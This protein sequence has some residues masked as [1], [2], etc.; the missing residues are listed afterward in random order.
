MKRHQKIGTGVL[1]ALLALLIGFGG[2]RWRSHLKREEVRRAFA[3]P[4][5]ELRFPPK[6]Y[7]DWLAECGANEP[8]P[9]TPEGQARLRDEARRLPAALEEFQRMVESIPA[10]YTNMAKEAERKILTRA[11]RLLD[12]FGRENCSKLLKLVERHELSG[13][14]VNPVFATQYEWQYVL[15]I[16]R[17]CRIYGQF[18]DWFW[19]RCGNEYQAA[20]ADRSVF[21]VLQNLV[22]RCD[23]RR[24]MNG[25]K[26]TEAWLDYY[27]RERCDSEK[28]NY[29]RAHRWGEKHYDTCW[30][31]YVRKDPR[32]AKLTEQWRGVFLNSARYYLKREP[33]WS[34]NY[35]TDADKGTRP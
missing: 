3:N 32:T 15:S 20:D 30:A 22:I 11:E 28:S 10:I 14:L 33:K 25:R 24:W 2:L 17:Y 27:K 35:K 23:E 5:L 6:D 19:T 29:C 1:L 34:P 13:R 21:S 31:E 9:S 4:P 26:V 8:D 12:G 18:A 7:S 16:D